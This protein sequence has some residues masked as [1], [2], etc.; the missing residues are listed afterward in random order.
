MESRCSAKWILTGRMAAP[1]W[2]GVVACGL[3]IPFLLEMFG[4]EGSPAGIA[5]ILGLAG[6]LFLRY[7]ILAAGALDPI[8]AAGFEFVRVSRPKEPIPAM[9]KVPPS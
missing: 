1:F 4:G 3:I 8:A 7:V 5:A 9:G 2:I 6:G